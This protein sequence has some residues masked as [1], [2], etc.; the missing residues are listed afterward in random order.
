[1]AIILPDIR[2]QSSYPELIE[3]VSMSRSG[4]RMV[5]VVEYADPFWQVA[6]RT[7]PLRASERLLVETFLDQARNGLVTV[8]Y[9]PQHQCLPK[10]Y[11]GSPTAAAPA[12]NGVLK[13][14]DGYS[15]TV[16][17]VTD[18]LVLSPGDLISLTT[19][20]YNW[21]AR[22]VTGGTAADGEIDL[23]LNV[24]VPSYIE[25]G[26]VARVKDI[27]ANM[28]LLPDSFSMPDGPLPVASFTLIEVPK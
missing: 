8:H 18:G 25:T 1:M 14:K 21:M 17:S 27:V 22:V 16:E 23:T 2:F 11:W 10:A 3:S 15:I 13:S 6:M 26:A 4:K 5:A 12:D 20:D 28:R 19:G 7:K 9:T 24:P